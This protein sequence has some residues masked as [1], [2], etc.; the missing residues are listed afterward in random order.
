MYK[1]IINE[2]KNC[3]PKNQSDFVIHKPTFDIKSINDSRKCLLS[4]FVSTNGEYLDKFELKLKKLTNSKYVL[5]T[6]SGTSALFLSLKIH[7]VDMTEILV[8]SMTFA[9]TINSILYNNAIPHFIDCEIDSPNIDINKLN[10]YLSNNFIV[11]NKICINKTTKKRVSCIMAVHAYGLP[12]DIDKLRK[13]AKKYYLEII[14]DGAGALGS[15]YKDKHIGLTSRASTLSFNGNKIVTT[16]MGGAILLKNKSDYEYLKHIMSTARLQHKW[17]V[18]HDALGYNL[19]MANINAAIGYSQLCNLN[20]ILTNKKKLFKLYAKAFRNNEYCFISN[21]YE[22]SKPNHWVINLMLK[23][24]YVKYQQSLL[25]HMHNNKLLLREL[26]KPQHLANYLKKYPKSDMSN[27]VKIW[28]KTISLPSC[29][30][31]K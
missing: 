18:E 13:I 28:K 29:Y 30:Y 11:K 15:Y 21:E 4:S 1:D 12:I 27:T 23:D 8:P 31:M 22:N 2:I 16:G 17:K 3:L 25:R 20:K 10:S 19:R 14:E 26:W 6:S 24:K 5:L 7:K 9:A